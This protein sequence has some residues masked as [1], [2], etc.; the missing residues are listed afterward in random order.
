MVR[1][2]GKLGKL[3]PFFT[4]HIVKVNRLYCQLAQELPHTTL[5]AQEAGALTT[6]VEAEQEGSQLFL[7]HQRTQGR[8]FCWFPLLDDI[9]RL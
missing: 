6:E 5:L 8:L 1:H 4:C 2:L 7:P 3:A 9:K